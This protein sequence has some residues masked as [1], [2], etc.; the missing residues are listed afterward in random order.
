MFLAIVL[1]CISVETL[2]KYAFNTC[3]P[4]V[5][6]NKQLWRCVKI[7]W[8]GLGRFIELNVSINNETP[9]DCILK[10]NNLEKK[11]LNET[12]LPFLA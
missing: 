2:V 12:Y 7:S 1:N 5:H 9:V 4:Q 10:K 8:A 11:N 6:V 3:A